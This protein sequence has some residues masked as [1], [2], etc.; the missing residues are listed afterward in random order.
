MN[1]CEMAESLNESVRLLARRFARKYGRDPG[2]CESV[3]NEA[4]LDAI[5]SFD[6]DR[7]ATPKGYVTDT[8]KRRLVDWLRQETGH[9]LKS[10]V[11]V[12][13]LPRNRETGAAVPL[14]DR[15]AADPA[16]AAAAREALAAG[17]PPPDAVAA[18]ARAL[19][20]AVY[21]AVSE[22]DV[23]AVVGAVVAK[24]KRGNVGAAKFVLGLAGVGPGAGRQPPD[25]PAVVVNVRDVT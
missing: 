16:D 9:R 25:S 8:V 14:A 4:F 21:A 13:L 10:A 18:K 12:G 11:R 17:L 7:G 19:R 20:A 5:D 23:A 24:A 2:D 6:P 3:A 22:Q 15:S 1:R